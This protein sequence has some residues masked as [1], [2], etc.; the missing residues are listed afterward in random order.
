MKVKAL[1]VHD[2]LLIVAVVVLLVAAVIH[3]TI[4]DLDPEDFMVVNKVYVPDFPPWI[5]VEMIYDRI[6]RQ[7][8]EAT[9]TVTI[10]NAITGVIVCKGSDTSQ[11]RVD[12]KLPAITLEWYIGKSCDLEP[13]KYFLSTLWE[14]D[15]GV[16]IDNTSNVFTVL[17]GGKPSLSVD[18]NR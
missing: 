9:W 6:I 5:D 12:E 16:L 1:K 13:G 8:F 2:S 4:R 14:L 15:N 17:P 10:E 11:Y 18:D 3:G 7:N